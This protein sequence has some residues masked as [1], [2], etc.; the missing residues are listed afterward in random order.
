MPFVYDAD[1]IDYDI[2]TNND[3]FAMYKCN[4]VEHLISNQLMF[5]F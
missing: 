1:P 2:R 5:S 3:I 4:A